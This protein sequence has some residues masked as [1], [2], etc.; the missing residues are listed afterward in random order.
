MENS[1]HYRLLPLMQGQDAL[2]SFAIPYALY[3]E[4]ACGG[5]EYQ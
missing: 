2:R 4:I 3:Q 1:P 5:F